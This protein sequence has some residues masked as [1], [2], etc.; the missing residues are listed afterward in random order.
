MD[1][2]VQR[3]LGWLE[4]QRK[5]ADDQAHRYWVSD[6]E[7]CNALSQRAGAFLNAIHELHR[8]FNT[9]FFSSDDDEGKGSETTEAQ[10]SKLKKKI[11]GLEQRLANPKFLKKASKKVQEKTR[12]ELKELYKELKGSL[13]EVMELLNTN[14][15]WL[16]KMAEKE[17]NAIVSV[18]GLQLADAIK[19]PVIEKSSPAMKT[20]KPGRSYRRKV[21]TSR[22]LSGRSYRKKVKK[23]AR[24]LPGRPGHR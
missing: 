23:P 2:R 1:E 11:A 13:G 17:D 7:K 8:I 5:R 21:K 3:L 19:K 9:G 20:R 12:K 10:H 18:G 15:E 4:E 24:K 6:Y 14:D 16:R 22:N